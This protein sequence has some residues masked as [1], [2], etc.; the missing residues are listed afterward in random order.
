MEDVCSCAKKVLKD[1]GNFCIVHR[2]DR[3]MDILQELRNNNLEPKK[4]KFVY[5][6]IDKESTLVLITAQK[7]GKVGL[8]IEKPLILYNLD[9]SLTD[10]YNKLQ[11]EVIV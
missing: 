9:G 1:N 7:C 10:E 3:L 6:T 11:K 2:S 4:V 8:R 5:E